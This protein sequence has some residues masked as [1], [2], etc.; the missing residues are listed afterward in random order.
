[1]EGHLFQFALLFGVLGLAAA[2]SLSLRMPVVPLYIA[3]GVVLGVFIVPDAVVGFLGKLGVVF[4]LFSMGLEFSIPASRDAPRF[5]ASGAIDWLLNFPVGLIAGWA[6]GWSWQDTVFLAGILYMSSSAV[7]AKCIVDFGRA[8]RPETETVL[9]IMVFEDLVIAFYLVLLNVLILTPAESGASA[10]LFAFLRAAAF[11]MLLIVLSRRFQGPLQRLLAYRSDEGFTLALFAFVLLVA[12]AAEGGAGLSEA[13]GAFLAGLVIGATDLKERASSTLLPFQTLFAALFFVS[14]GMSLELESMPA[15]ALPGL[16][17]VGVGACTK[18]AG[19]YLAG[20][21]SGH[22]PP[23]SAVVGLSLV[24][25]GEF[26]VLIA[27]LAASATQGQSQ[28]AAL[29]GLYVFALSIIGPIGMR[30]ADRVADLIRE[31]LRT[32]LP[33]V[34]P[35]PSE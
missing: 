29:T 11:I 21:V 34:P 9:G 20:R 24:P 6:L 10:Y 17:L 14:F 7:V 33:D 13:V 35:T 16:L 2:V 25:K 31:R 19:G 4:L 8:A 32:R 28:I 23:A 1:V 12:S 15:V 27:A 3:A 18:I 26:S 5:V 22:G 30:E